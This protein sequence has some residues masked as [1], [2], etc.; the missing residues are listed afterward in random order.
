[1]DIPR[2]EITKGHYGIYSLPPFDMHQLC[3]RHGAADRA[4]T[5]GYLSCSAASYAV[6]AGQARP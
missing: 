3:D 6:L 5:E 1:M 4:A 2:K